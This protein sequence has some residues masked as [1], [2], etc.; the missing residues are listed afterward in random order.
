MTL[1][2][3]G[4]VS[5]DRIPVKQAFIRG[6]MHER[7]DMIKNLKPGEG[8]TLKEDSKYLVKGDY[9]ANGRNELDTGVYVTKIEPEAIFVPDEELFASDRANTPESICHVNRCLDIKA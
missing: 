6:N 4:S 3:S 7:D 5:V 8:F 1:I 2:Q 9:F